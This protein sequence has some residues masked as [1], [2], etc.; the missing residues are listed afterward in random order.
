[1][2]V[3]TGCRKSAPAALSESGSPSLGESYINFRSFQNPDLTWGFTIFVN[4][5]PYCHYHR[6]PYKKTSFGFVSRNEAEQVASLFITMI[7][8]GNESLKLTKNDI[9]TLKITLNKR[10]L[11]D[12]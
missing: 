1:L 11:L 8:N 6:I 7:K 2:S 5:T 4:S 3:S 12:P 10:V 9:D